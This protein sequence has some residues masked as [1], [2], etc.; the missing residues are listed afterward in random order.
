MLIFALAV[1]CKAAEYT[2]I[3]SDNSFYA[4]NE[5]N[6]FISAIP[7]EIKE[8]T[9]DLSAEKADEAAQRYDFNFFLKEII[10]AI[11]ANIPSAISLFGTITSMVIISGIFERISE[12]LNIKDLGKAF[13][14]CS[15]LAIVIAFYGIQKTSFAAAENLLKTLTGIMTVISPLMEAIYI[16]GGNIS[17]AA[18]NGT[19]VT[20]TITIVEVIYS[21]ILLPATTISLILCCV[22]AVTDNKGLAYLSKT[23]RI[24]LTTAIV[25]IMALTSIALSIQ[26]GLAVSTDRFS[27]RAIRFAL[28]S[29]VPLIGGAVSESLSALTGSLSLIKQFAGTTGIVVLILMILPPVLSLILTRISL[30]MSSSVSGIIGND[31]IKRLLEDIGEIYTMLIS[32][33]LSSSLT[34]IYALSVFCR[35]QLALG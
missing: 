2:F 17:L 9:G 26:S 25:S 29:Y 35:S 28:G 12:S 31:K 13:L 22:A 24:L 30:Y 20:L 14:F 1:D 34:F 8:K 27:Q 21:K 23:L 6:D 10:S 15:T 19:S 33:S 11:N 7:D 3:P 18:V 16:S 32:I 4:E 5:I